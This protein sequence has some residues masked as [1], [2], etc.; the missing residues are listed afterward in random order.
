VRSHAERGNEEYE[1]KKRTG[2]GAED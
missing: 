2:R 1:N